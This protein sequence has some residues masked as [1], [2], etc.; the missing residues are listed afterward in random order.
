MKRPFVVDRLEAMLVLTTDIPEE[1]RHLHVASGEHLTKVFTLMTAE[2][3]LSGIGFGVSLHREDE[4][5]FEDLHHMFQ[6]LYVG[7]EAR[8]TDDFETLLEI[9]GRRMGDRIQVKRGFL[10]GCPRDF[11]GMNESNLADMLVK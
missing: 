4:D 6:R 8:A 5:L 10:A 11:L 2:T 9:L 3:H 1:S 7:R